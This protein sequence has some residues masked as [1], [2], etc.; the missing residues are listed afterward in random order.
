VI[1]NFGELMEFVE[2]VLNL[3]LFAIKILEVIDVELMHEIFHLSDG[4]EFL[5]LVEIGYGFLVLLLN[6]GDGFEDLLFEGLE[7][8]VN[9]VERVIVGIG[10][11]FELCVAGGDELLDDFAG[12][13]VGGEEGVGVDGRGEEEGHNRGLGYRVIDLLKVSDSGYKCIQNKSELY[14]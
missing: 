5:L 3:M 14:L 11:E 9:H 6:E 8:G 12:L 2:V 10:F 7:S 13:V 1:I 4:N